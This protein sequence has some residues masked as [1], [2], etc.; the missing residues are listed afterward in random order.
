MKRLVAVVL[1]LVG[2]AC[3]T[4]EPTRP[5][6]DVG[7]T[8]TGSFLVQFLL[9]SQGVRGRMDMTVEQA[10]ERVTVMGEIEASGTTAPLP[11]ATGTLDATGF[12]ELAGGGFSA[13]VNEEFCGDTRT[14][15]STVRFFGASAEISEHADTEFCG[16]VVLSGSLTRQ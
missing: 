13:P 5:I 2:A 16:R 6:P 4:D 12:L 11:A 8:Y 15:S 14:I 10:G 1:A 7:G 9:N 3:G